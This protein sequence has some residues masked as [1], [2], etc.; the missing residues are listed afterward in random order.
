MLSPPFSFNYYKVFIQVQ[1]S[2]LVGTAD[3]DMTDLLSECS[4]TSYMSDL[5]EEF[6]SL[7]IDISNGPP[8]DI[9]N[10]I[11]VHYNI[12]SILATD[13]IDQLTDICKTLNIDVLIL[14]ESKLDQT[15]PNNLI[16]IPGYHEPLRHDRN[17]NGR[18]GG[19]VLMYISE[20]LAYQHRPEFQNEN[21]EHLWADVRVNNKMFAINAMYRPPNESAENHQHFLETADDILQ[22]LSNYDRA[23]YKL[24]SG[25][26]NFGNCYCKIPILNPKPLDA[27]APDLFSSFGF[28][29]LIDIPTRVTENTVSLI[30]LIYVNKPDDVICHGTLH[31]IADHDGVLVSFNTKCV[32][33]KPKTKTIYDYKNAD[34]EGL[35]KFIKDFDFENVVFSKPVHM[36]TDVYSEILKQGFAQFVPVKTI[37]IRPSD[38]PWCNSYT[39]L[40]LRKKN[41][42]YQI[43]KKYETDYKNILNSNNPQPEIV[44]R[45]L[46]KRD[47]SLKK[48]RESANESSKA[49][50]RV[51]NAYSNTINSVLNNPSIT[52]KKKFGILLKL[53]KNNKFSDTPPLVENDKVINDPY[54]KSN[55]FNTFFASKSS[56]PDPKDPAPI[57]QQKEGVSL[58]N[59]LNTSPFEISKIIRNLKKSHLSHCGI[60]GK[61]LSFISTPI[62][63]SMSRLFNNLFET[64]HFPDLWKIAHVT[65]I[66]KR[67]GPKTCKSSFRPI[68]L[69]PSLSKIYESV[70]HDRLLKHCMEN[71]EITEKQAAYLKGDS[72]VS[73]LLYIV[74]NIRTNWTNNKITQGLFLD[75]SSAFDKVWHNGLLAKLNQIGVEGTFLDT[76]QSYLA[77]RKQVVVVDGVKSET[78]KITAGVPQ[79]SRLGPLLFIIYMNDIVD[80]IESDILIFADDTSLMA[81]GI[82]PAETVQQL[83]RD[84]VKISSWAKKWK[85]LFN[86]KKSKDIIFSKKCLNNSPPL[87]FNDTVIDRVNTH[88]HL[89]LYLTSNLDFSFQVNEVCLKANRKL[90]VLRSVKMLS[91]QTL[92][93]LYKLTV[94]S[95]IDYA[96]PVYYKSLKQTDIAHLE[97]IQYRAGKIVTGALHYTSKEKLNLELGWE[98]IIDRGNLLSLSIFHKI[99]LHETRPLIRKFMPK[100]DIDRI[101]FTRSKGGYIPFKPKDNKFNTSF[102]PNTLKLWNNLTKEIQCKDIHEFKLS[103]KKEIKPSRYKHFSRGNKFANT[104]LTR[105]RVGRSFLNQ[106]SFTIGHSDSPECS[107]H[108]KFESPEHYFLQ[109]FL[110]SQERQ[111]MFD[112]FEHYIPNFPNLNRKRKLDIIL[113]GINIDN[114]EFT[115]LNIT[116]TK[117]VQNF[118]ISTKRFITIEDKD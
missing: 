112:L 113:R 62:S 32:K 72:T 114:E 14:S 91:R 105:I 29:Q 2:L 61:F 35:I 1:L 34:I 8:I 87:L 96:L 79:G 39:R 109:C 68:S 59:S 80:D 93:V 45:Y 50:R 42:N 41:R 9:D 26:L 60:P 100:L 7:N 94:R 92:D 24:M 28:Q 43:Y 19:G 81:S 88:K 111:T 70:I 17:L 97:N 117:G 16:T 13:R 4:D 36:Q 73:Q 46:N 75:V 110:Y 30:S 74:H 53:M 95:V 102:F 58:I 20:S 23:E 90:A 85:V 31:K 71:N 101:N 84:L 25:D 40:L 56:V 22:Q 82:D 67:S 38:A 15:I 106:H 18:H 37:T 33:P 99:H 44:T 98:T 21:Y 89:G 66:Y 108:H 48:S 12:N 65:A 52:A 103:V 11:I 69:L 76:I 63:F 3:S 83:N 107:C 47:K 118:I 54:E 77:E 10:F 78:L 86:A 6:H 104:L 57:L 64:G 55:I 27:S 115:S 116:L 51:K 5:E 49:N